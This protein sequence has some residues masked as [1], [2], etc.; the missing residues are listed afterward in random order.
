MPNKRRGPRERRMK[1]I[2]AFD[3]IVN[4]DNRR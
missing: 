3:S 4:K 1:E 2:V